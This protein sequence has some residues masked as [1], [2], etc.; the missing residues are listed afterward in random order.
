[1]KVYIVLHDYRDLDVHTDEFDGVFADH[2]EAL[3]HAL[4]KANDEAH[5]GEYKVICCEVNEKRSK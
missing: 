4:S 1:M 5:S 2:V 3:E